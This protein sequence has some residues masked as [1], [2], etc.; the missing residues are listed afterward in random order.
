MIAV[1]LLWC[2]FGAIVPTL[3]VALNAHRLA[4]VKRIAARNKISAGHPAIQPYH[5]RY[6]RSR[7]F[8]SPMGVQL[9]SI[10]V[11]APL[12]PWMLVGHLRTLQALRRAP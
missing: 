8:F 3:D 10:A 9:L 6:A 11:G 4:V 5:Q 7:A 12:V 1:V 2:T